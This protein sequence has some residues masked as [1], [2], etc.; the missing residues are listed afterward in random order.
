MVNLDSLDEIKKIDTGNVLGSVQELPSQV[1]DAF[2]EASKVEVP[3]YYADVKN[4]IMCGM[5]GSGLGA[6]VIQSVY[7]ES[8]AY[9]LFRV[10][11][12]NLPGY[13][14]IH[15][16]VMCS[17]YSGETEETIE[18]AKQAIE[19]HAKWMA[20]GTGNT[21]IDMAKSEEV[22]YYLINPKFN[23]S[24]QPRMAIGYSVIG[25]L[26]LA[27]KAG[28]FAL[29]EEDIQKIIGSMNEIIKK[30]AV[31]VVN[32]QSKDLA[33]KLLGKT[34]LFVSAEH[35][36]GATHVVNNQQNENAKNLTFDFAIPEI[37]HH[38]LEGLK[39]PQANS[40]NV[41]ILFFESD[42]YPERIKQRFEITKEVV[43]E[44]NI[45]FST[46]KAVSGGKLSEAFEIIQF[47]AYVNFYLSMLYEQNPAPLPWVDFFKNRLGQP[48]G[49]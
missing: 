44:N 25:Q 48:L 38:L 21:L 18:N 7:G 1:Q 39:H 37:N 3:D 45:E 15:S 2:T 47:G 17:S 35:L 11:D 43:S 36:I 5:G 6:R 16:L 8:L 34:I 12:Y 10:N 42:I 46:F 41:F 14:D 24:N 23:P 32:N 9:P 40:E 20:I 33:R 13:T 22:P 49:K 28:L 19:R 30:E 31:G 29:N 4:I 26:V 27:S